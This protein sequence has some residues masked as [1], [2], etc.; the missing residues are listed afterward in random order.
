MYYILF[1]KSGNISLSLCSTSYVPLPPTPEQAN[2]CPVVMTTTSQISSSEMT[3]LQSPTSSV[4]RST[5]HPQE[6]HRLYINEIT[7][8]SD[9]SKQFI[10][11]RGELSLDNMKL[12]ETKQT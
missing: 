2:G 4:T 3:Y 8:S 12:L 11:L 7:I 5:H 9:G 1:L 6:I 10:E